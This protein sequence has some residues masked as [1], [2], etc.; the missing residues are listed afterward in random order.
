MKIL[1]KSERL[2]R[3]VGDHIIVAAHENE[4]GYLWWTKIP[5]S[6]LPND[7]VEMKDLEGIGI[8][9]IDGRVVIKNQCA[10]APPTVTAAPAAHTPYNLGIHRSHIHFLRRQR[11]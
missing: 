10:R 7:L 6:D 5:L 1:P 8:D 3:V 4:D 9:L 2:F 11:P